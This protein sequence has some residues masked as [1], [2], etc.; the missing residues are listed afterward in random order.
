[1]R[2]VKPSWKHALIAALLVLHAPASARADSRMDAAERHYR[3]GRY[4]QAG[5]VYRELAEGGN[6]QAQLRL[7]MLHYLGRGVKEDER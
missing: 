2:Y 7:G 5:K 6:V 4:V 1:M 3:A